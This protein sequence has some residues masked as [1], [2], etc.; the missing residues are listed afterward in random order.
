M[1]ALFH[2]QLVSYISIDSAP[3]YPAVSF[4][5]ILRSVG[6]SAVGG[7]CAVSFQCLLLILICDAILGCLLTVF[8]HL[9]QPFPF[10]P[11]SFTF[12]VPF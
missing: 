2:I 12:P 6:K 8:L 4:P 11:L 1:K 7:A 5:H 9:F 10:F 3:N